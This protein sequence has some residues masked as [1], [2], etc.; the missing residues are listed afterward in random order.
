MQLG[1][2]VHIFNPSTQ[3]AKAG[4]LR[5]PGQLGYTGRQTNN[6]KTNPYFVN[7]QIIFSC[8]ELVRDEELI[9]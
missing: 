2:V 8:I 4:G 5:V 1:I 6:L 9:Q 3:E 7:S